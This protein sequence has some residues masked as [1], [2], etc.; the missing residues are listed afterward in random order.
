MIAPVD[1]CVKHADEKS[2]NLIACLDLYYHEKASREVEYAVRRWMDS[3]CESTIIDV[4]HNKSK[5]WFE[6]KVLERHDTKLKLHYLF[7][8][9]KHNEE[10]DISDKPLIYP[11]NTHTIPRTRKP[12]VG[13]LKNTEPESNLDSVDDVPD[14]VVIMTKSGRKSV[15]K[16]VERPVQKKRKISDDS[17]PDRNEWICAVCDQLEAFDDSNL[18]LCDG[19]CLR[20]FHIGC[21]CLN[22][23]DVKLLF[24]ALLCFDS[25][26]FL[27]PLGC[28]MS[29]RLGDT[30]ASCAVILELIIQYSF[31]IIFSI[32][33]LRR[34]CV[35]A[36]FLL[37]ASIITTVV[38]SQATLRI[39]LQALGKRCCYFSY[40]CLST[41]QL[42]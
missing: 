30:H 17:A 9:D 13:V 5:T 22:S 25:P 38:L 11:R 24:C 28:V 12:R 34:K 10:I 1:D 8:N 26:R 19:P 16:A 31:Y 15:Q 6:A 36:P 4:F 40:C 14:Q 37:A 23:T 32:L 20:S 18:I 35:S 3:I 21:L 41:I 7:W 29:V 2:D 39:V 27:T 42:E 33:I